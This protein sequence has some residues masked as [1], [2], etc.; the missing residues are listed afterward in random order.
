MRF[1]SGVVA[2]A[3]VVV[4]SASAPLAGVVAGDDLGALPFMGL[5]SS[6][7]TVSGLSSGGYFAVQ[8]H[9]AYSATFGGVGV[10]A[11]GPFF[12]AGLPP[13]SVAVAQTAC[14]TNPEL[15]DVD[16]LT[17]ITRNTAATGT[18]DPLDG[19]HDAH[20]FVYSGSSDTVVH[21]DVVKKLAHYYGEFVTSPNRIEQVYDVPAEHGQPTQGYGNKCSCV[22]CARCGC[23]SPPR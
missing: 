20:V 22:G 1:F 7:V 14:M 15:I 16:L 17:Q 11:G 4:M 13:T 3:P 8:M 23:W 21:P 10:F 19:L 18:I 5:N 12:C 2:A 9:V 6:Y